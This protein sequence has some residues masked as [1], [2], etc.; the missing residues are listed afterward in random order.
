MLNLSLCLLLQL[1]STILC[2][3]AVLVVYAYLLMCPF[4]YMSHVHVYSC[5]YRHIYI[6]MSFVC[7]VFHNNVWVCAHGVSTCVY[8]HIDMCT[9]TCIYVY[10]LYICVHI[11]CICIH[12]F[13]W[14]YHIKIK[15]WVSFSL[16]TIEFV[17][18]LL[19]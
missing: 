14:A 18:I 16:E 12:M 10:V 1:Q 4:A 13:L 6:Y 9:Y 5:L 7:N 2:I 19:L 17:K 8:I 15:A 11:F 3:Y